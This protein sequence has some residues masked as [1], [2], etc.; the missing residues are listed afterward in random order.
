MLC[1]GLTGGIASGKTSVTQ[2]FA[3]LGAQIIDADLVAREVI[4]PGTHAARQIS[5]HFGRAIINSDG[6]LDR[7]KLRHIIFTDPDEKAWLESLIHP[8]VR[9]EIARQLQGEINEDP[10]AHNQGD[11]KERDRKI[12]NTIAYR[13]LVS[14]LLFETRQDL[15]VDRTLVI[16]VPETLQKERAMARDNNSA[17]LISAIMA[18]QLKREQRLSRADDVID[19]SG[20][21]AQTQTAIHKLHLYYQQ[22]AHSYDR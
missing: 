14:P 7:A 6:Q 5:E 17:D 15:L 20:D 22:L 3:R 4:T 13:I 16:D 21:F 18:N 1:V 9:A 12:P 11:P 8:L 19:N 10:Q 2:E